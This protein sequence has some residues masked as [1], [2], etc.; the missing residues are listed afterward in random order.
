MNNTLSRQVFGDIQKI[1]I[2]AT[3]LYIAII[4]S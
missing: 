1:T 4:V 2:Y 3:S